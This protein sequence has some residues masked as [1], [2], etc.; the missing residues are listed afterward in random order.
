MG[1]RSRVRSLI[2][3]TATIAASCTQTLPTAPSRLQTGI[4]IYE[5]ANFLGGSAHV[6]SDIRNLSD[7][8][9][10][11]LHDYG[12]YEPEDWDDCV[13]SIRVAPG[14]RFEAYRDNNFRGQSLSASEDVPNLQLVAGTCD[15][16]GLNDCITSIR[17]IGPR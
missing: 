7:F 11:C 9:G 5:H 8:A 13:S 4:T 15:G 3:V 17:V 2:L 16:K 10:P 6:T 14:W 1:R 12:D